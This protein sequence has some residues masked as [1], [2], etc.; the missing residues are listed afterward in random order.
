MTRAEGPAQRLNEALTPL[1]KDA[2]R[3]I[4]NPWL[5]NSPGEKALDNRR[6]LIYTPLEDDSYLA[7]F[8]DIYQKATEV[9]F[10]DETDIRVPVGAYGRGWARKM[11]GAAVKIREAYNTEELRVSHQAERIAEQESDVLQRNTFQGAS[12]PDLTTAV[13]NIV[14]EGLV[15]DHSAAGVLMHDKVPG[16]DDPQ[17]LYDQLIE[18]GVVSQLSLNITTNI[19]G[20][21]DAL[22]YVLRE[23][24]IVDE[25]RLR[26]RP[27]LVRFMN[28][29]R[30][31]IYATTAA[32]EALDKSG[33][34]LGR[35][36]PGERF[37]GVDIGAQIHADTIRGYKK[38]WKSRVERVAKMDEKI[39]F[40]KNAVEEEPQIG[41]TSHTTIA[42]QEASQADNRNAQKGH[43]KTK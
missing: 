43:K 41:C 4:K 1:V 3:S 30:H 21:M 7:Q 23:P 13:R 27:E 16:F 26:L 28:E 12:E 18:D 38:R 9:L 34:P 5:K 15:S 20:Q 36:L 42:E 22:G 29:H 33:C 40:D 10:D 11:L 31:D 19:L 32:T 39:V 37:S 14:D 17:K 8:S 35:K 2:K 25:G 6:I 24:V